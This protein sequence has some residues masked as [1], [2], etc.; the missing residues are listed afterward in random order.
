MTCT[1][2]WLSRICGSM[3]SVCVECRTVDLPCGHTDQIQVDGVRWRAPKKH[4]DKAWKLIAAGDIWWDKRY[5]RQV[6]DTYRYGL[7]GERWY[8]RDKKRRK[9]LHMS[10]QERRDRKNKLKELIRKR[11]QRIADSET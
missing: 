1:E 10:P 11:R 2:T 6:A 9:E 7:N 4:N 8:G 3:S 5:M